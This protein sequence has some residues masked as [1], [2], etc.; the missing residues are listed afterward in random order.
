MKF[1]PAE[2]PIRELFMQ[3]GLPVNIRFDGFLDR[4]RRGG[5]QGQYEFAYVLH[6]LALLGRKTRPDVIPAAVC[7]RALQSALN[8]FEKLGRKNHAG[9]CLMAAKSRIGGEGCE[10][11]PAQAKKWL[12]KAESLGCRNH[13]AISNIHTMITMTNQP[14]H[15]LS[16]SPAVEIHRQYDQ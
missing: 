1:E 3:T 11:D 15:P 6:S 10:K 13:S 14:P 9:S 12:A 5:P 4:A 2:F 8:I 7:H 16:G